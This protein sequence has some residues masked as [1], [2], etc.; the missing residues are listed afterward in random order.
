MESFKTYA[1]ARGFK[2]SAGEIRAAE[3]LTETIQEVEKD[4]LKLSHEDLAKMFSVMAVA[5]KVSDP[6][7]FGEF[8][9]ALDK[10]TTRK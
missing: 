6:Y 5:W 8:M 10:R 4:A 9:A 2:F 3:R 1:E 7:S